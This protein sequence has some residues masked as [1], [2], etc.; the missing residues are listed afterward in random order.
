[1]NVRFKTLYKIVVANF[2]LFIISVIYLGGAADTEWAINGKFY[3]NSHGSQ[4][5]VSE[6][7]FYISM[8]HK[9]FALSSFTAFI[10]LE[11]S[12]HIF[13]KIRSLFQKLF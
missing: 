11:L 8:Y 13:F 4:K 1:M 5:E 6:T 12:A 3:V 9:Y 10:L 7:V 2:V